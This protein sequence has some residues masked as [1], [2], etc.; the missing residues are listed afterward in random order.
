MNQNTVQRLLSPPMLALIFVLMGA[1]L[2][3]AIILSLPS[4]AAPPQTGAAPHQPARPAASAA[5]P[6]NGDMRLWI[7]LTAG[8]GAVAVLGLV[9][10]GGIALR[11]RRAAPRQDASHPMALPQY[12][13]AKIGNDASARPWE[14]DIAPLT[15]TAADDDGA[16]L[17]GADQ[18]APD[19]FDAAGFTAAAGRTFITLQAAWD[20]G[21]LPALRAL[22]T[23][24]MLAETTERLAERERRRPAGPPS[25]TEFAMLDAHLLG[26][27]Q[28]SE[29][30]V[31]S[32]EFS[33]MLREDP[34]SGLR[35]F[36]VVWNMTRPHHS[37]GD[38]RVAG[39]QAMH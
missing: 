26:I 21:D 28:L 27:E 6:Q 18:G 15:G 8:A 10:A 37:Q 30:E 36:R 17:P 16:A 24:E 39:M 32:V 13:P 25:E 29:L 2:A 12:N 20:K 1:L 14:T 7:A 33:G 19:G 11:R 23:D 3:A 5:A 35:P 34:S 4:A 38:W 22:M 9:G 31:A